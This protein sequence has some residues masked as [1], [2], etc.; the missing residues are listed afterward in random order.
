MAA[1]LGRRRAA[2]ACDGFDVVADS[3]VRRG[4]VDLVCPERLLAAGLAALDREAFVGLELFAARVALRGLPL[5]LAARDAPCGL[6]LWLAARDPCGLLVC[7]PLG[8]APF[9]RDR[10]DAARRLL[11]LFGVVARSAMN[12]PRVIDLVGLGGGVRSSRLTG[13]ARER[14]DQNLDR[15][16]PLRGPNSEQLAARCQPNSTSGARGQSQ[17]SRGV[18]GGGQFRLAR[19]DRLA[20]EVRLA[21]LARRPRSASRRTRVCPQCSHLM[22]WLP[23][24]KPWLPIR[25]R[26]NQPM[27]SA[28]AP[29]PSAAG[30]SRVFC[31]EASV[32]KATE[33]RSQPGRPKD[34]TPREEERT[35]VDGTS[36][37]RINTLDPQF[38]VQSAQRP[39][40]QSEQQPEVRS[41]QQREIQS[42]KQREI[43]SEK[44][45]VL[46]GHSRIRPKRS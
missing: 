7:D 12:S 18:D 29:R 28:R 2:L 19:N 5:W 25:D 4:G 14:T 32:G 27:A 3:E 1:R 13:W 38:E 10:L 16:S 9:R 34:A 20:W 31:G 37:T 41:E 36:R 17:G 23:I 33:V 21:S 46:S 30:L 43:Q 11:E 8:L 22:A 39:K 45:S 6:L 35:V 40:L 44:R 42:E 15:R 26:S 24:R